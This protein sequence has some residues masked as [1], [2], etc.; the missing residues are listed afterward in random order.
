MTR[1]NWMAFAAMFV[2]ALFLVGCGSD[3]DSGMMGPAG[4][5]GE[6]PSEEEIA[7]I[8]EDV[9]EE[10]PPEA[11]TSELEDAITA[12]TAQVEA[13]TEKTADPMAPPE[14][15]GGKKSGLSAA[16]LAAAA[17]KVAG[18]LNAL[19]DHDTDKGVVN[20]PE[21]SG[22]F[23]DDETT[24]NVSHAADIKEDAD[25]YGDFLTHTFKGT[26]TKVDLTGPDDVKT[27]K[28]TKLLKVDGVELMGVSMK[29]TSKV[30]SQTNTT[31][32]QIV[33]VAEEV[34][35]ILVGTGNLPARTTRT[36]TL[37]KDGSSSV[38]ETN[39]RT[40]KESSR[41]DT[42]FV[43]GMKIEE[44]PLA[45][46]AAGDP[47][48]VRARITR[49]DGTIMEYDLAAGA[50][51]YGTDAPDPAADAV[52]VADQLELAKRVYAASTAAIPA[53]TLKGYGGWLADSFFM[54]YTL[55][56][57]DEVAMKVVSGGREH[58]TVMA[59][60]LS[61]RGETATWK[62]LM[63]GHDMMAGSSTT[64][65]MLKGNASVTARL[66]AATL[67]DQTG[68]SADAVSLV[69]V[70]L[71][72]IITAGGTAVSRVA[73]GIHWTNLD[74]V[75]AAPGRD[76]RD[77][78]DNPIAL[79]VSFGKGDEINGAFYDGG[80]EVVGTF[81]KESI[82]GAFGAVEYEMMDEMMDDMAS[83]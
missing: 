81:N 15:L 39:D 42:T 36:M 56:A 19:H 61:G 51:D 12:L 32:E 17:T 75:G 29:E 65:M 4:P 1:R 43:G 41:T 21:L 50:D 55:I 3:G 46:A 16:D 76:G 52:S 66:G 62:G 45:V 83:N 5:P 69:D 31:D 14:I 57:G 70:S 20:L 9:L 6:A 35:D 54:A 40:G 33:D 59:T 47:D 37:H 58:D 80:D 27:L 48:A 79:P 22:D 77:S 73:D 34:G 25:D 38:V 44:F 30:A 63:V 53:H 18:E 13:L 67:A 78:G 68:T 11:D 82:L 74:L 8:V 71:T 7:E 24:R 64:G 60:S 23:D 49:A 72:N 28:F 10:E 2:A 26:G